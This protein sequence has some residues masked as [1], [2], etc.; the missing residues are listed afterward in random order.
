VTPLASAIP[1]K[2]KLPESRVHRSRLDAIVQQSHL[3]S[4]ESQ[5]TVLTAARL[6]GLAP[7]MVSFQGGQAAFQ[8]TP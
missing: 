2:T 4:T 1:W 7:E 3:T 5:N 6:N 8:Q